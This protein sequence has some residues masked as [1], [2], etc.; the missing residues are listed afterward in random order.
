MPFPG[1]RAGVGG[2]IGIVGLLVFLALPLLGGGGG[3]ELD[4]LQLGPLSRGE[5]G[6]DI[7]VS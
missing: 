6:D 1:G 3:N 2:G 7:P 5:V 4:S